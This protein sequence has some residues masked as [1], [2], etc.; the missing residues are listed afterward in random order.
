MY[1]HAGKHVKAGKEHGGHRVEKPKVP[2]M[3]VQQTA[4]I[5]PVL[6]IC[7]VLVFLVISL[8]ICL[9]LRKQR[10]RKKVYL[11]SIKCVNDQKLKENSAEEENNTK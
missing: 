7:G 2:G 10:K 3:L 11:N 4:G 6:I 5:I 1:G 8:F 9:V